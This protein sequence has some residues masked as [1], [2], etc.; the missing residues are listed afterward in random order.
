MRT[1]TKACWVPVFI[2][3][4]PVAPLHWGHWARHSTREATRPGG[5]WVGLRASGSSYSPRLPSAFMAPVACRAAARLR[6]AAPSG[7]RP[8]SPLRDSAGFA[9]D[10]PAPIRTTSVTARYCGFAR[11][12]PRYLAFAIIAC[13]ATASIANLANFNGTFRE[14]TP[15]KRAEC[16]VPPLGKVEDYR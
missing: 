1:Q 7:F 9:P 15:L 11:Y 5:G 10:F 6:S 16:W 13:I 14:D 8:R 4:T 3:L 12:R 2:P